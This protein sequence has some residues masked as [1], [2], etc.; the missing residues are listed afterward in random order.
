GITVRAWH[1]PAWS[2]MP[3]VYI[4]PS[5]TGVSSP[6]YQTGLVQTP[7]RSVE[8]I[9]SRR[10]AGS[11][12]AS[13]VIGYGPSLPS[14]PAS[15]GFAPIRSATLSTGALAETTSTRSAP[16]ASAASAAYSPTLDARPITTSTGTPGRSARWGAT[17]RQP[18]EA[19][20]A[21]AARHQAGTASGAGTSIASA[22]GARIS[23]EGAPP[24]S[25]PESG[26][27]KA[28]R[29]GTEAQLPV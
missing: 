10:P 16:S 11:P 27:P 26:R 9:A 1:R 5:G 7:S 17:H 15:M 24:H 29:N 28:E 8:R 20:S 12:E 2:R 14:A 21:A 3:L 19:L 25:R 23:W 22:N 13:T 18:S 6:G 4:R